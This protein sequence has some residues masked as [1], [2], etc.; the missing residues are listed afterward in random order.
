MPHQGCAVTKSHR[1]GDALKVDGPREGADV[2]LPAVQRRRERRG[3]SI[4]ATFKHTPASDCGQDVN[5]SELI[6]T[7][8]EMWV[9]KVNERAPAAVAPPHMVQ[10]CWFG[11]DNCPTW[12]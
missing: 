12:C 3:S 2:L 1:H 5:G 7:P 11:L 9:C 10:P 4:T 8:T 6:N